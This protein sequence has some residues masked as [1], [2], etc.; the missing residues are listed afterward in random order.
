MALSRSKHHHIKAKY[1]SF[2][3][4][5]LVAAKNHIGSAWHQ[6]RSTRYIAQHHVT[7]SYHHRDVATRR[8]VTIN[9]ESNNGVIARNALA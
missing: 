8:S 2:A 1:Q 6:Q 9:I 3:Q 5:K 4:R 7:T